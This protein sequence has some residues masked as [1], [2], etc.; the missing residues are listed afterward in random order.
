MA[1]DTL[2]SCPHVNKSHQ[3]EQNGHVL[4]VYHRCDVAY[5]SAQTS[6]IVQELLKTHK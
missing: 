3:K 5:S 4:F 2:S 1:G 6:L